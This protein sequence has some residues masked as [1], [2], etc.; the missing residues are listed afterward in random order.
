MTV[1]PS[2]ALE[3]IASDATVHAALPRVVEFVDET[4]PEWTGPGEVTLRANVVFGTGDGWTRAG[5]RLVVDFQ[6]TRGVVMAVF[7]DAGY[8]ASDPELLP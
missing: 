2:T 6:V 7:I 3:A 4:E 1:V 8:V 5:L